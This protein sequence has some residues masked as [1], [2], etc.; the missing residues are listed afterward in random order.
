M[1]FAIT[2]PTPTLTRELVVHGPPRGALNDVATLEITSTAQIPATHYDVALG[3]TGGT[4]DSLPATVAI[5]AACVGTDNT[6][7]VIVHAIQVTD[8]YAEI[9]YAAANV[10]MSGGAAQWTIDRWNTAPVPVA[11]T[12]HDVEPT[13]WL[14]ARH[15]GVQFD[16]AGLYPY[17]AL[18]WSGLEVDSVTVHARVLLNNGTVARE[19]VRDF[20]GLPSAI[21]ISSDDVGDLVP[22][23]RCNSALNGVTLSQRWVVEQQHVDATECVAGA[24][25]VVW[26]LLLPPDR[27]GKLE[28]ALPVLSTNTWGTM[29]RV[30]DALDLDGFDAAIANGLYIDTTDPQFVRVIVPPTGGVRRASS[31]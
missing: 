8:H 30:F 17:N 21:A 28:L 16:N 26:H 10:D 24:S 9:G 11:V 4:F 6:I 29:N 20:D 15:A 1:P 3:C 25:G 12:A 13:V 19:F 31:Y 7:A 2:V 27:E 18:D 5:P 22:S 14:A 23:S